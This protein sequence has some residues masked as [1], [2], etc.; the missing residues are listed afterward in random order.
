MSEAV[1]EVLAVAGLGYSVAGDRIDLASGG[2]R[3]QGL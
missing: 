2:T 3:A 1:P